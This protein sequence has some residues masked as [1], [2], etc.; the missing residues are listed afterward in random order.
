MQCF[1]A[2]KKEL[3]GIIRGEIKLPQKQATSTNK[4]NVVAILDRAPTKDQG[5][6]RKVS[7]DVEYY[8]AGFDDKDQTRFGCSN[9]VQN[10]FQRV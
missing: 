1:N 7:V 3:I 10:L 5:Y 2:A 8:D 6:N 9:E 4:P